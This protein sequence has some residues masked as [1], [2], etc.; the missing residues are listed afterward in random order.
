MKRL[1][2]VLTLLAVALP[3][4]AA[5]GGWATVQLSSLPTGTNAEGTWKAELLVLQHGRTPLE[6]VSPV[7]RIRNGDVSREFTATATGE[8]GRYAVDVTFPSAGTWDWE[9]WDG[10]SQTHTYAPVSI[11]PDPGIG[12]G[13]FPPLPLWIAVV[14]VGGAFVFVLIARRRRTPPRPVLD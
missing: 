10:F 5:A 4:A 11:G 7:V 14:A 3:T 9:I 12:D 2:L 13:S 6:N 8:P 1:F